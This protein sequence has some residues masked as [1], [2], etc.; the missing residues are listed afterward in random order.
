MKN[1]SLLIIRII[2]LALSIFVFGY[3]LFYLLFEYG[4]ASDYMVF[5]YTLQQSIGTILQSVIYILIAIFSVFISKT[6][7][8][9]TNKFQQSSK[10]FFR[11][12]KVIWLVIKWSCLFI[13]CLLS[14]AV[15][16]MALT[17][18]CSI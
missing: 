8:N 14:L 4:P 18:M 1:M 3:V 2:L 15:I 6:I 11:T 5:C 10:T 7:E 17:R 12:S 13:P 9:K 16:V